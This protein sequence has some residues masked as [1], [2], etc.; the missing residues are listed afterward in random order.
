MTDYIVRFT[1]V[2]TTP[3]TVP[4]DTVNRTALD[5]ALFGRVFQ[6]YGEEVNEDLL[7]LLENFAC[8]EDP[9]STS[10]YDAVP[11]LTQVSKTQLTNPTTGEFWYNSS[12]ELMYFYDGSIW[13]PIPLRG[14][15]AANWGQILHGQQL[16]RPVNQQ[17]YMFPYSECIWSVSPASINGSADMMNCNT[18]ANAQVTMQWRYTN[19]NTIVSGIANYLI[20]GINGNINE[21]VILPPLTPGPTPTPTVTPTP[22]TSMTP[23]PSLTPAATQP[24]TPTP[25]PTITTTATPTPVVSITP[26]STPAPT[27]AATVTPTPTTSPPPVEQPDLP[28]LMG[29][30]CYVRT[31]GTGSSVTYFVEFRTD[32]CITEGSSLAIAPLCNQ[33]NWLGSIPGDSPSNYE[34]QFMGSP[35]SPLSAGT[36]YNLGTARNFAWTYTLGGAPSGGRIVSGTFTLRRVGTGEVIATCPVENTQLGVNTEC[37]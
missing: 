14:S 20:I 18:D 7:N 4:E 23:T 12:R 31:G 21:G 9:A 27:P 5:V 10:M 29:G 33:G 26:S 24:V 16:P 34:I 37:L 35:S 13:V 2:D 36:W 3:I 22:A 11:D 25:T 8:P 15:Y 32:G 6:N 17:G 28:L 19:T 1:D 30:G